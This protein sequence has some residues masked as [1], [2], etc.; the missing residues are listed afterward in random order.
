[1]NLSKF[2]VAAGVFLGSTAVGLATVWEDSVCNGGNE[3]V[4]THPCA[5]FNKQAHHF[6]MC[7]KGVPQ[8]DSNMVLN[9]GCYKNGNP[10]QCTELAAGTAN[11]CGDVYKCN[12]AYVCDQEYDP[13]VDRGCVPAMKNPPTCNKTYGSCVRSDP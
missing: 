10:G 6:D 1:M 7:E 2:L 8:P 3:S 12:V 5:C 9:Y 11:S 13:A 4:T